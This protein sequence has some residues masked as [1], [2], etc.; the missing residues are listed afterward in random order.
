MTAIIVDAIPSN[1]GSV[2][3]LELIKTLFKNNI[4]VVGRIVDD[5]EKRK[6]DF[7]AFLLKISMRMKFILYQ[8][9]L[10]MIWIE[11]SF[12]SIAKLFKTYEK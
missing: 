7:H 2:K 3:L 10:I 11:N 9:R 12:I 1:L 5:T 8:N 4:V 6:R